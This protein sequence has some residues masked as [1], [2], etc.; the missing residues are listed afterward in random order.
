MPHPLRLSLAC[1]DYDRTQSLRDGTVTPEGIDLVQLTLPV[2]ETFYRMLR[3]AEFDVAEMSLSSYVLSLFQPNPPFIAIPAFPS[4][5]FRHGSIY[6]N[7]GNG[8][9]EPA[10]L[11]GRKVG[12]PEYQMTAA[13]WIRGILDEHHGVA[14]RDVA[15]RTGGLHDAGRTEKIALDLPDGFDVRPIASHETLDA[16]L[17]A[18]E[19]DALY[20]ARAPRS[21]DPAAPGGAVRRLFPDPKATEQAYFRDTGIFPIMHTVVIRRDVY[22]ADRWVARSLFDA[23]SRAKALMYPELLEITAL[24]HSLP[25]GVNEAED[26]IA[27]MGKDFWPYGVEANRRTLETFLR[28]S[29]EHG[30]ARKLLTPEDLFAPETLGEVLI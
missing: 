17:A 14:V 9:V 8:V 26:T 19:I 7:A 2:E 21:F 20:S 3:H 24:K 18:G 22:E 1:W 12:I 16:L 27:L 13:V 29:H 10:D 25:W 28:Y 6:V 30:L 4:R 5:V 23:F 11:V 15:Y